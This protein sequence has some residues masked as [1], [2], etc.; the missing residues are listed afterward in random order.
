MDID[1][2]SKTRTKSSS[3]V[4]ANQK[5]HLSGNACSLWNRLQVKQHSSSVRFVFVLIGPTSNNK[6]VAFLSPLG[7]LRMHTGAALRSKSDIW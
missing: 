2:S 1:Q 7:S 5:Q 3:S 6:Q 4:M